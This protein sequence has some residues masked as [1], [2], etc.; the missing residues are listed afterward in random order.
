[1]KRFIKAIGRPFLR[2]L[3]NRFVGVGHKLDEIQGLVE[4]LRRET[5]DVANTNRA[6]IDIVES[7]SIALARLQREVERINNSSHKK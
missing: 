3:N 1:M 7:N 4:A 5:T 6:L 2:P